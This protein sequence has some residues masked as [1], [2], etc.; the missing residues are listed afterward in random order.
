VSRELFEW[1]SPRNG[2]R[3]A[4]RLSVG[5]GAFIAVH[6][7]LA[8]SRGAWVIPYLPT[9]TY[10]AILFGVLAFQSWQLLQQL[11]PPRYEDVDDRMPWESDP[12]AWKR[13]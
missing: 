9:S 8:Q 4:L 5:V 1:R 11:R 10:S 7:L 12:D 13:R 3:L 6:A 2:Q